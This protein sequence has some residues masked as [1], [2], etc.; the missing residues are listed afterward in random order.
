MSR[1]SIGGALALALIGAA[2]A[3]SAQT[4]PPV[5]VVI[6]ACVPVARA[7]VLRLARIEL[8][9]GTAET[10]VGPGT[11]VVMVGCRN[12]AV[13]ILVD[14]PVT[15]KQ[16]ERTVRLAEADP[17]ARTRLLALAIAELVTTS[18]SEVAV[19]P[20]P[21]LVPAS[22]P[23]PAPVRAA[24]VSAVRRRVPALRRAPASTVAFGLFASQRTLSTSA[25]MAALWGGGV[26]ADLGL[27]P[28]LT[29][30][31]SVAVERGT[32][33]VP[34]GQVSLLAPT[35]ALLLLWRQRGPGW[36]LRAGGGAR[37]GAML[38]EGLP[39]DA[40]GSM[41]SGFAAPWVAPVF[42]A[43]ASVRVSGAWSIDL[44]CE[45]G[46]AATAVNAYAGEQSAL[47]LGGPFVGVSLGL[48]QRP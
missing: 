7:E 37:V 33:S 4:P 45:V 34:Q 28:H 30:H 36:T 31:G 41:G 38:L 1:T 3:A 44:G 5:Q 40:L 48:G 17:R 24:V 8:G 25:G 20:H 39:W 15:G 47:T 19:T 2:G 18:W 16:T 29:L 27:S 32:V 22:P 13:T 12:E 26:R 6:D 10:F 23:P 9:L 11:T 21:A 42:A 14:D 46:Y 43:S 35:L